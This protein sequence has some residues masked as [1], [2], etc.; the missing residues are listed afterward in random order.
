MPDLKPGGIRFKSQMFRDS[1]IIIEA[2]YAVSRSRV[3][4]EFML[5]NTAGSRPPLEL[6]HRKRKKK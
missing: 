3:S 1:E 4:W 6:V 5:C 2:R